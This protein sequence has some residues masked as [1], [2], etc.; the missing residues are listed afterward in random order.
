MVI[1]VYKNRK[2]IEYSEAEKTRVRNLT[3]GLGGKEKYSQPN[4]TFGKE[5]KKRAETGAF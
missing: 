1:I 3:A 4:Q 2:S 5:E